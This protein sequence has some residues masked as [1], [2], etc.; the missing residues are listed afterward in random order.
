[1]SGARLLQ[2]TEE[3]DDMKWQSHVRYVILTG[4][5]TSVFVACG[6]ANDAVIS[7]DDGGALG[8]S[9]KSDGALPADA[10]SDASPSEGGT[11]DGGDG[12]DN[13]IDPIVVGRRWTYDVTVFGTYPICTLGSH[14]G[15]VLGAMMLDG[16]RAF[17]VQSFCPGL[18][19]V[20]YAVSGDVVQYDYMT[21][22]LLAL[23]APVAEGHGWT[24]GVDTFTWHSAGSVTVPAG[25]YAD[26]WKATQNVAYESYTLFC[27]G[28]GPVHWYTKNAGNG[29]EA[30]LT[31]KN[32]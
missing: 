2:L 23:D 32:F 24:N 20:N 8:D 26:C 12:G 3:D 28:V 15:V 25:T 4:V 30:I 9:G 27:R 18:G 14:D 31:A 11:S 29:Y 17:Q 21:T 22:W 13:R 7:R 19:T 6:G 1:M 10:T 5:L 16:K